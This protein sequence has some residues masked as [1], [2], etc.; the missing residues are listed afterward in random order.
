MRVLVVDDHADTR[1]LLARSLQRASYGASKAKDD[2]RLPMTDHNTRIFVVGAT[3]GKL[4]PSPRRLSVTP[5]TTSR[6]S[7]GLSAA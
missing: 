7:T 5:S 6:S 3:A 4:E 2:G 1:Q